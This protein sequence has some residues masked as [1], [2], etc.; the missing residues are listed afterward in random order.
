MAIALA[1][2]MAS[3]PLRSGPVS[4]TSA[5]S[6]LLGSIVSGVTS[7]MG[8]TEPPPP[9]PTGTDPTGTGELVGLSTCTTDTGS[10][11]ERL[12]PVVEVDSLAWYR[13]GTEHL[14][15]APTYDEAFS[16]TGE[17]C[18]SARSAASCFEEVERLVSGSADW[19][20]Y[21]DFFSASW[22]LLVVTGAEAAIAELGGPVDVLTGDTCGSSE[23]GGEPCCTGTPV[24]LAN[25]G[26]TGGTGAEQAGGAG[27]AAPMGPF[28]PNATTIADRETLL[29]F[30]GPVDT[31]A[32]G[33]LVMWA[34]GFDPPCNVESID[35]GYRAI[36]VR[37][38]SD[39]PVTDQDFELRVLT[40]G[41]LLETAASG[42]RES[43][44]CVGRRPHGLVRRCAEPARASFEAGWLAQVA[45]LEAAAVLAFSQ[46]AN[47]LERLGAP[48]A[49]ILCA[50]KAAADEI[51]H[52]SGVR[53]L[54]ERYGA[55]PEPAVAE[56]ETG[57]SLLSL[58]V[59]NA[60]EG[61]VRECWGALVA[62]YQASAA[63]DPTVRELWQTIAEDESGHAV[64]SQDIGA[65]LDGRLTVEERSLVRAAR[66]RAIAE[67][68]QELAQESPPSSLL[69]LPDR[70][71][72]LRLF[73]A[74]E[75][76]VLLP[77]AA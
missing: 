63:T 51:R 53:A 65:W 64:L 66:Q 17:A 40:D 35:G 61:C 67:L 14:C 12:Q 68:R 5:F 47:E 49:L 36:V 10:L 3:R 19:G 46:L 23:R 50:R 39:C 26:A 52:A 38:I 1:A 9:R 6:L 16:S 73:G 56:I 45:R 7:C 21:E 57:R 2:S 55:R 44:W 62:H 27:G 41:T 28:S 20:Q 37:Q 34:H 42:P 77:Q 58:A 76:R 8:E 15:T 43:D 59:E 69:G 32:E 71:M 13:A 4:R 70:T 25:D 24:D 11:L 72:R 74:L 29:A 18:K 75:Q 33:A 30:L 54:A 60:V 22:S 31:A 48:A